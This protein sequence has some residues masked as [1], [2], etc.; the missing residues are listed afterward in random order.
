MTRPTVVIDTNVVVSGL[1]TA[2]AHSPM[3][4]ILDAV[5]SGR[6]TYL[7]SVELF[8]EYRTVLGR[9]LAKRSA[10]RALDT[11]APLP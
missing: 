9:P 3:A 8:A 11:G 1:V 6:L 4:R 2:D 10:V 5:L 7:L